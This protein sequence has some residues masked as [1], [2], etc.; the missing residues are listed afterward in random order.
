MFESLLTFSLKSR[1]NPD[2]NEN[3]AQNEE[4]GQFLMPDKP[5]AS[6]KKTKLDA[7]PS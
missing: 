4:I 3:S 6:R 1:L 5:K 7:S 2:S